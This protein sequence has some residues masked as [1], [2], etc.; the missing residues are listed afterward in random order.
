[1]PRL[2]FGNC[3]QTVAIVTENLVNLEQGGGITDRSESNGWSTGRIKS[4]T[5]SSQRLLVGS[6]DTD[7][8]NPIFVV[9]ELQSGSL[10]ATR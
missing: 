4:R 10:A 6:D 3:L 1:M 9:L 5:E 7:V 8:F 2:E